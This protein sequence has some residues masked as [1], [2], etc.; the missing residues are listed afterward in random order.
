MKYLHVKCKVEDTKPLHIPY[1]N[2]L[3]D[4][5]YCSTDTRK[6]VVRVVLKITKLKLTS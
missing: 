2:L 6:S 5:L 4:F 1:T 3:L